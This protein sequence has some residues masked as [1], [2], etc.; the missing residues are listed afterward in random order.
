MNSAVNVGQ[1]L[2]PVVGASM[3]HA[4]GFHWTQNT[5]AFIITTLSILYLLLG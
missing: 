4:V 2:G 5:V 3:Y 1:A